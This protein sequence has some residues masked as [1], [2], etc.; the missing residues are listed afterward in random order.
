[1]LSRYDAP[2]KVQIGIDEAG[3]GPIFGRVYA[4]AVVLHEGF[5]V[6]AVADSKTYTSVKKRKEAEKYIKEN[7]DWSVQWSSHLEIDESDILRVTLR[8]M[9]KAAAA[10][11]VPGECVLIV[12]GNQFEAIEGVPHVTVVRGDATYACVAAASILAKCARDDYI[13]TLCDADP[14]LEAKYDLRN[15]KGYATKNHLRGL[16][17]EGPAEGHRLSFAPCRNAKRSNG[18]GRV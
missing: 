17:T 13:N 9:R 4:A 16:Q 15:N 6:S 7:S 8:C 18:H 10:L 3:R 5:D 11:I 12:D 2:F 1:M 14:S